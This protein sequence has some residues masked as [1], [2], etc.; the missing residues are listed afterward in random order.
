MRQTTI[1][2]KT[3]YWV[4]GALLSIPVYLMFLAYQVAKTYFSNNHLFGKEVSIAFILVVYTAFYFPVAL[5]IGSIVG[6]IFGWYIKKSN[7]ATEPVSLDSTS[8][9]FY[10]ISSFGL[11]IEIIAIIITMTILNNS[12]FLLLMAII[13][14]AMALFSI[15]FNVISFIKEKLHG[16]KRFL[17]ILTFILHLF[18]IA[19]PFLIYLILLAAAA[20]G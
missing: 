17:R 4:R 9:V 12:R 2:H 15:S 1:V 19:F 14:G 5:I 8:K 11:I 20:S 13:S 3:P 7:K 18:I 16:Y 6:L 10:N